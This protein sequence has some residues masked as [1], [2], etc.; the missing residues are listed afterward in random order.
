MRRSRAALAA[1]GLVAER[2]APEASEHG[3]ADDDRRMK[4]PVS[5][6]NQLVLPALPG[7]TKFEVLLQ[8]TPYSASFVHHRMIEG[9]PRTCVTEV[10]HPEASGPQIHVERA[11][12]GGIL[13]PNY[14]HFLAEGIHRLWPFWFGLVQKDC[15]VAFH[16]T[17]PGAKRVPLPAYVGDILAF[18][19][20]P[21]ANVMT[22]T[23]PTQFG[24]LIIPRQGKLLGQRASDEYNASFKSMPGG[25]VRFDRVYVS[26]SRYLATGSYL[27]EALLESQ[28]ELAGFT[29][30]HPE[31]W[32]LRDLVGIYRHASAIIFSE[33]SPIHVMEVTGGTAA[34]VMIVNRR[35]SLF[36]QTN[37]V[38]SI[39]PLCKRVLAFQNQA[40]LTPL[41]WDARKE[42]PNLSLASAYVDLQALLSAISGFFCIEVGQLDPVALK[43]AIHADLVK[44]MFHERVERHS[45]ETIG[46]LFK[47]LKTQ[48]E[49]L[50]LT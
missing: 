30:I 12:Y 47:M 38:D 35:S 17:F 42:Q 26:R 1:G 7:S 39:A 41:Y 21:A 2:T 27:G 19:G 31:D 11:V 23:R 24:E 33:G 46:R 6:C 43:T 34:K 48:L 25:A 22:I 10:P 15:P 29:I 5:I 4:D 32:S 20:I 18:L 14:G 36:V 13:W 28:L 50:G 45:D 37:F 44:V 3:P 49:D 8:A 16:R 9:E 40:A